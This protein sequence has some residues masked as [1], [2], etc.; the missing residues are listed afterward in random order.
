MQSKKMAGM[1]EETEGMAGFM[2]QTGMAR[3]Y[4]MDVVND[5]RFF[6]DNVINYRLA[7]F[8]GLAVVSGLMVQNCMGQLFDMD[9]NMQIY[10]RNHS[11]YHPNGIC[12]LIAFFML[13]CILFMNMLAMYIGVAQPY[14]TMRLMTAGPTGFDTAAAYYLNKNIVTFRH[15][16]IKGALLSMPMYILQMGIRM[17]V[18]FDRDTKEGVDAPFD[19]PWESRI[20]AWVFSSVMVIMAITLWWIHLKHFAVFRDRYEFMSASVTGP[21]FRTYMQS[22][23]TPKKPGW[24]D[25]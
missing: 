21:D 2:E 1:Y 20:Q 12:Q 5:P 11:I 22:T 6:Q 15:F 4:S 8:G 3:S 23:M 25:V 19:T 10:T 9:K 18:K 14:H 17:V 7:A 24:L 16:A 13:V